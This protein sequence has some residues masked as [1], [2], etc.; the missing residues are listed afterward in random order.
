M[1]VSSLWAAPTVTVVA[2]SIQK[3]HVWNLLRE[4]P[5]PRLLLADGGD[6]GQSN[7]TADSFETAPCKGTHLCAHTYATTSLKQR[8]WRGRV[9]TEPVL[10]RSPLD[11][12]N[13]LNLGWHRQ[14]P[15][16]PCLLSFYKH[17]FRL[18]PSSLMGICFDPCD[19]DLMHSV[20]LHAESQTDG[21]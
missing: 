9:W 3:P 8:C 1:W 17:V 18:F 20:Y 21:C 13:R 10:P 4:G 7:S 2:E 14:N 11:H 16:L 12:L 6:C 19:Q 15:S 5:P